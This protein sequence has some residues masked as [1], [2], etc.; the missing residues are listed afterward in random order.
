MTTII[1]NVSRV[2]SAGSSEELAES[3]VKNYYSAG[4][5]GLRATVRTRRELSKH[6]VAT[7]RLFHLRR[8]LPL[9]NDNTGVCSIPAVTAQRS[10]EQSTSTVHLIVVCHKNDVCQPCDVRNIWKR[11]QLGPKLNR[12]QRFVRACRAFHPRVVELLLQFGVCNKLV[13]CVFR[14]VLLPTS[15]PSDVLAVAGILA[16]NDICIALSSPA[17]CC[18]PP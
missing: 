17:S 2:T 6:Q 15:A 1:H 4:N 16:I 18:R 5:R 3:H 13:V 8:R 7:H 12:L 11:V 10:K 14:R 9:I